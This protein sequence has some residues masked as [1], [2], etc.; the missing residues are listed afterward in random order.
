MIL[1][2]QSHPLV[3]LD[4]EERELLRDLTERANRQ[5]DWNEFSNHWMKRVG[6][7]C[8]GRGLSRQQ[9]RQTVIYRIAQ[10]LASRIAV[11]AGIARAPDYRDDLEELIRSRFATRRAFCEATGISE[12]M[13][14]HVL[15]R[16]KHLAIE[17]LSD[18][19]RRIGYTLHIAPIE[20]KAS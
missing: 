9:T 12:D 8:E 10:D 18:A 11:R 1:K 15:A 20:S 2:G 17:T 5:P 16:R 7:F 14:S 4:A 3:D 19:L 6:D 13:L